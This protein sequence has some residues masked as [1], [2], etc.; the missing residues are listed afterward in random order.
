[1][2]FFNYPEIEIKLPASLTLMN[3][4]KHCVN[5]NESRFLKPMIQNLLPFILDPNNTIQETGCLA[6]LKLDE[7]FGDQLGYF[8][9]IINLYVRKAYRLRPIGNFLFLA[10]VQ[11]LVRKYP[12]PEK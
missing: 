3:Y 9:N 7:F 6:I 11:A 4:T 1:M 10:R 12:I 2:I 8:T 5:Y